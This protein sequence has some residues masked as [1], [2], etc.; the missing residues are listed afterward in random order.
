M[1]AKARTE[2]YEYFDPVFD[3]SH[4][5]PIDTEYNLPDYCADVQRI[6]KCRVEPEISSYLTTDNGITCDGVCD[7]R[8]LYLDAKGEGIKCCDF[9]K[10]FS[11]TIPIKETEERAIAAVKAGLQHVN[12]RAMNARRIDLH[13]TI[14][15]NAYAVVQ[16]IDRIT[17]GIEDLTIEKRTESVYTSQAVNAV[18]HQFAVEEYI[19]LKNGKPPIENILRKGIDCRIVDSKISDESL[20]INGSADISFLYN[21]FADGITPEKMSATV[22]FSQDIDCSGADSECIS[23]LKIVCGESSIQPKEDNMGECTGVTVFMKIFVVALIYRSK[24]IEVISDAYSVSK[25]VEL[26]YAQNNFMQIYDEKSDMLKDKCSVVVSGEEIQQ[27]IDIWSEQAEVTS[28]CDKNKLNHRVRCTVCILF[29]NANGRIMYTEKP[30]DFTH[31]FDLENENVKK[32]NSLSNTDIWEYRISD[33]NT[34][35]ISLET[36]IRSILYSR[37]AAK[38]LVS[39]EIDED[40]PTIPKASKL[41]VYYAFEGERL[42]DIAKEH[43]ALISDIRAQNEILEDTISKSGPIIM[44]AN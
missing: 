22:E 17:T 13:I 24:E 21:S 28:Y 16:K 37:F 41:L 9:T 34:V 10:D 39:A 30:F 38:Q 18:C 4:E 7:I 8:I 23:D 12:C 33:K 44:S 20:N 35:E 31:S 26:N 32:C 11:A 6:L 36:S 15:L 29:T 43:K 42:W 3:G 5:V 2:P 27:V 19:P 25:P 40:A 14:S 1:Q